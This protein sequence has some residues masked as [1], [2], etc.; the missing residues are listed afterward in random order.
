MISVTGKKWEEKKINKNTLDKLKQD[1]N[2]SETLSKLI[3]SRKFNVDEIYTIKN[4]LD[5]KN[6]FYN[7]SDFNK[8]INLVTQCIVN[9]EKICILGDYDVD[10]SASTS[11]FVRFFES[12][13]HPF[14]FYI[15]D[16]EK[17]GYGASKK[18]FEKLILKKP[19]LIIMVDCGSTS[20]KAIDFLNKK[21]VKSL[22]IDHHEINEPYPNANNIINPKKNNGYIKYDYMC[23][24]TL[25]YFFLELL[26]KKI[27]AKIN[28]NDFLVYV[29]LA[30][31]CDVMPLRN[32]NRLI[33]LKVLK[34]FN[35]TENLAFNQLYNLNKKKN[36]INIQDLGYMI[37]PILNAGG[38]LGKSSFA[39]ELLSSDNLEIINKRS[40]EL[41][42][43]N[44]K[45]KK[46][47]KL[48]LKEINFDKI[49]KENKDV[50]IYYNANINEGLIGIIAS[51]LKDYF[52]KPAL[53][54]TN[55]NN[56]LKGSARSANNYNIGRYM[57]KALDNHLIIS[58]GGHNM[59]AGFT[60]RK[61]KLENFKESIL[62][63]FN[64][65]GL[66]KMNIN[67]YDA[68]ISSHAFNKEFYKEIKKIEPFGNGNPDPVFL[69]KDLK[70]IKT[71]ILN[72]KHI[73]LILKS[74]T[75][76]SIKSISFN[77]IG[78]K[79]GDHLLNYKKKLN[80]LGQINENIW[81]NKNTLQF[82][83]RDLIL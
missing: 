67:N 83:V 43:L 51:R 82:T 76:F 63:S 62:K 64:D 19:E 3:I 31:I 35:I 71:T 30:T 25:V 75:G 6:V 14:F 72:N 79:L 66:H 59:A 57:K 47:E 32:M 52:D 4:H 80:V 26:I 39:T 29:L 28:I 60:L 73:S 45:R 49:E 46:I 10:G 9:K 33:S 74:K 17:D 1:Y 13:N 56:V 70:I 44:E 20:N 21:K 40:I 54:I 2:F 65:N 78:T 37:G 50:I 5:L 38:R 11:L 8:S 69:I 16:R 42:E 22:I 18:L 53:V 48:I 15:P 36:K 55:S 7:N 68:E 41:I 12:I 77:S 24:T 58:G 23:A 34:N 27:K 81:N 61:E